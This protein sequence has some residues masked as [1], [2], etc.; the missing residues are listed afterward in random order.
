M[1]KKSKKPKTSPSKNEDTTQDD[2]G[3]GSTQAA[4]D[5][6]EAK[7]SGEL[8]ETPKPEPTPTKKPKRDPNSVSLRIFLTA[9]GRK[10]DQMAGFQN[11]AKRIELGPRTMKAW[12]GEYEKFQKRPVKG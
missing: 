8:P 4:L 5:T 3:D 7:Q 10:L 6:Y 12:N 1:A 9:G 11:Y 2:G